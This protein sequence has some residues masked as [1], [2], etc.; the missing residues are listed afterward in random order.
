MWIEQTSAGKL[1]LYDRYMGRDGKMHKVSVP[2]LRDTAQARRKAQEELQK[3]IESSSSDI[4]KMKFSSLIELY[5]SNKDIKPSSMVN[6]KSAFGQ[7]TD[8]IGDVNIATLTAPYILRRLSASNKAQFT[9][10]RY[11]VL[12]NGLFEWSYQYGYMDQIKVKAFKIKES[13]RDPSLEYLETS[14][15]VDVLDQLQ[16]SMAYYVTKFLALTGCRI[17]EAGAL[18]WDDIDDKYIHITKAYKFQNGISTPKTVHSVRDIY[19]QPELRT[20][21]KEYKE[22][23]LLDMMAYGIRTDLL[24][25]SRAGSYYSYQALSRAFEK[26]HCPKH[27]HPHILRHTHT[28]LLAEQGLSL[29][30]IARRLGHSNS[31]ITKQIYFHV[32]EKL[33]A[34]DEA[35]MDGIKILS[36]L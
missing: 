35:A 11:I 27:L 33:K 19:I 29:E 34:R 6:Y 17:G 7:L 3:K 23:R 1:R 18:T 5:L 25:Y 13:K 32:T 24:F 2:L 14:E 12:L 9:L 8:I 30:A 16:G 15:L 31:D 10:N 26:V 21:L 28:A 36:A 4:C 20:L 22:W